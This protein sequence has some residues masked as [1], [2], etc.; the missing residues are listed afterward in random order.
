MASSCRSG[1]A[2]ARA[3]LGLVWLAAGAAFAARPAPAQGAGRLAGAEPLLLSGRVVRV[4]GADS[5]PLPGIRIVA[6]R[7]GTD[8]Q[9]P[10]DSLKSDAGGR[11][12]FTVA[13]PDT[14]AMYVVS[15]LYAGIGYFSAPYSPGARA[16]ADSIL[17]AV[18]DTSSTGS[19]L[20]VAVRHLVVSAAD[21]DGSRDV[22]D[23]VQVANPGTATLVPRDSA[24]TWRM[25]L[26]HGIESFR[27]GEGEV[28][29]EAVRRVGDSLLV[30][31]PF[32]PGIKQVVVM[33]VVPQGM[34]TL[35][36]PIDQPTAK[37]E[38]LVE[39]SLANASGAALAAA[40][41]LQL[42][43]RT[44]RHFSSTR[45]VRG[46]S[47]EISFGAPG[48]GRNLAWVAIVL[49]A[50]L[51][52]SGGYLASRRRAGAGA[53]PQAA[54]VAAGADQDALVRQI[55]ALDE[56]YASRQAET[57]P[58]EWAA[59]QTRRAAIKAQLAGR[60]ARS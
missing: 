14:G 26:P 11:F 60:L 36:V 2:A 7:V 49:S 41:P 43:G 8:H 28:P 25:L 16:G 31:A 47:A 27:V 3:L 39:D 58:E 59:Y 19:P 23:I 13:R 32:P 48:G 15:T 55:V 51:L 18:F 44:F 30:R 52:A 53:A 9:G 38:V 57:P 42:Q 29:S 21:R 10:V 24:P 54:A 6:H 22:L 46:E 20:D 35:R 33:Y 4:R 1:A 12:S 45:V 37:L 40:N 5:V 50:L 34:P 17:L 56:R